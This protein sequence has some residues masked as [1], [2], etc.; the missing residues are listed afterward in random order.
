MS[1]P[2]C[3]ESLTSD[4]QSAHASQLEIIKFWCSVNFSGNYIPVMEW[5]Q[6]DKKY[7][8]TGVKTELKK[9]GNFKEIKSSLT[10]FLNNQTGNGN[11]YKYVMYFTKECNSSNASGSAKLISNY[12][13]EWLSSPIYLQSKIL[14]SLVL[15]IVS[16]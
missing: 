2:L 12:S 10:L 11:R 1:N 15:N 4:I 14:M 9:D 6:N 8:T 5:Y 3:E 13:F 16:Y 7:I